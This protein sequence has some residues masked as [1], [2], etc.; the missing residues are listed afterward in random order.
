MRDDEEDF[1]DDDGGGG[2]GGYAFVALSFL[3][4]LSYSH[5][6]FATL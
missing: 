5:L 6:A 4:F 2:G 3:C 1:D